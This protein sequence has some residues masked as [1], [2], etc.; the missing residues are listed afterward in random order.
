MGLIFVLMMQLPPKSE[1]WIVEKPV[2]SINLNELKILRVDGKIVTEDQL[3][4]WYQ[5]A[6]NPIVKISDRG[7]AYFYNGKST[8]KP[9]L[10]K[11]RMLQKA[12]YTYAQP[13]YY[14]QPRYYTPIRY[15]QPTYYMQPTFCVNGQC[16]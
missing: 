10:D 4:D 15:V 9:L 3:N 12:S 13:R 14:I 8:P 6:S 5:T 7:D 11:Y 16:R 1:R 2:Q